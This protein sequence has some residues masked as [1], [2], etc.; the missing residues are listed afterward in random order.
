MLLELLVWRKSWF[1]S[2][3]GELDS[4]FPTQDIAAECAAAQLMFW[5]DTGTKYETKAARKAGVQGSLFLLSG[6]TVGNFNTSPGW[7]GARQHSEVR[8]SPF[9]LLTSF[10]I[11]VSVSRGKKKSSL[12]WASMG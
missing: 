5:A 2:T 9:G 7:K 1:C 8:Q 11:S 3:H 12:L 6:V 4:E 10:L